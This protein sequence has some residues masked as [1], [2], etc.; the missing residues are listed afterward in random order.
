MVPRWTVGVAVVDVCDRLNFVV[1]F[2][3]DLFEPQSVDRG[4]K[5]FWTLRVKE[6][7]Y[8]HLH[9]QHLETLG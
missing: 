3:C 4:L 9:T 7:E 2:L 6:C 1:Y 5:N 8:L